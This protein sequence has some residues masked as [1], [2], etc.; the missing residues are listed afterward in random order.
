MRSSIRYASSKWP[1]SDSAGSTSEV[2]RKPVATRPSAS[3]TSRASA[4]STAGRSAAGHESEPERGGAPGLGRHRR[5]APSA[6]RCG[7]ATPSA[8]RVAVRRPGAR[9]RQRRAIAA[10]RRAL[11]T[12]KALARYVE[13]VLA[14]QGRSDGRVRVQPVAELHRLAQQPVGLQPRPRS[15]RDPA[16]D[17]R[18]AGGAGLSRPRTTRR[19]PTGTIVA[20]SA[21][22]ARP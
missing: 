2:P 9:R 3:R 10:A 18:R 1:A 6:P 14:S 12:R 7:P 5:V 8:E 22:P 11:R 17:A 13:S 19:R 21:Q 4:S 20:A 15:E 16:A